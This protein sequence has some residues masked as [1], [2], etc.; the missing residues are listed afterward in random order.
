MRRSPATWR[1][2]T[3]QQMTAGGEALLFRTP[4]PDQMTPEL[5]ATLQRAL[6]ARG[7]YKGEVSGVM[8]SATRQAVRLWQQRNQ[9]LDSAILSLD[10]ARDLGLIAWDRSEL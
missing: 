7:L 4:C 9:G 3:R 6:A 10:G 2:E 5:V 8:D 1:S